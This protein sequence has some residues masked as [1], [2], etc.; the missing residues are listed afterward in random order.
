MTRSTHTYASIPVSD[1]TYEKIAKIF[2]ELGPDYDHVLHRRPGANEFEAKY[3]PLVLHGYALLV[4]PALCKEKIDHA[5]LFA[6]CAEALV[7]MKAEG[8]LTLTP[9]GE[10]FFGV[11]ETVLANYK[12]GQ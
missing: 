4:D 8:N 2:R 12:L 10:H 1:D 9:R 7:Q 6:N 11:T 5:R 3:P